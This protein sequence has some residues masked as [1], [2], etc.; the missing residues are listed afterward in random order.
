MATGS[1][2]L[3]T[4]EEELDRAQTEQTAAE[5]ALLEAKAR[6]SS[7]SESARKLE[8]AVAALKGEAPPLRDG[9]A[10]PEQQPE[11][12]PKDVQPGENR[13]KEGE[14]GFDPV[15]D[16]TPEEYEEYR[17]K[18]DRQKA[19]EAVQNNP[20]GQIKCSGCGSQGSLHESMLQAP[21]GGMLKMLVCGK[22]GNQAMM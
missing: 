19:K 5:M 1:K 6:A 22:C 4:L 3:Q 9:T 8:A 20:Y 17:R 10:T 7:A 18:K 15:T 2:V 21:N 13:R 11:N 12:A 14:P 16:L